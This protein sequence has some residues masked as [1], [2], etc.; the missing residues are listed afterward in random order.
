MATTSRLLLLLAA[1]CLLAGAA[2][3]LRLP[4]DAS[5]PGAQA[6]RLIRALNL[7][8]GASSGRGG[9]VGAGAEDVAPGQLLER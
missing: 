4:P 6:E 5:F 2:D 3:A 7:L 1:V 9:K 8:P